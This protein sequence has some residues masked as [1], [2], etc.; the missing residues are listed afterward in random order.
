MRKYVAV[1]LFAVTLMVGLVSGCT[2]LQ[3][4]FLPLPA[5]P[6]QWNAL[7]REVRA[8]E[9]RIGFHETANF[10][11]VYEEKGSYSM[12]GYTSPFALPY[13]YEDPAIRWSNARTE[14]DCRAEANG[15]DAYFT[16]IEAMGEMGVALTSTMLEGKL[17]RFLYV[18]IHEDCHDQFDLPYG[19]E[20]ALCNVI[21]YKAMAAFAAEK[22][23]VKAREDR[24]VQRYVDEQVT[25]TRAVVG[26][27]Q[28]LEQLY[29]RH[30]RSEIA[31]QAMLQERARIFGGAERTMG[32]NRQ[33]LNNVGLANEMTYSRHYAMLENVHLAL[34]R[35]LRRTVAFFR[36][37]DRLKPAREAVMIQHRISDEKDVRL[38]RAYESAVAQTIARVLLEHS[39][40]VA[41]AQLK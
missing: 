16:W 26:Y 25:L 10:K 30:A 4:L 13:S 36:Q 9:R 7:L 14:S 6:N 11:A 33:T 38:V 27:Y 8:F 22:Y 34:G 21:G 17:D 5:V 35:D 28:Q 20:E 2:R 12:C 1:S 40:R 41:S 15:G 31:A 29:G 24:A 3:D 39:G 32:W 18:V 19:I 23:G 37:V